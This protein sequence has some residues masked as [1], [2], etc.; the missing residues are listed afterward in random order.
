MC[1]LVG[2][3]FACL[4]TFLAQ[5]QIA[6]QGAEGYVSA[7]QLYSWCKLEDVSAKGLCT[8]YVLGVLDQHDALV[9]LGLHGKAYCLPLRIQPRACAL[10]A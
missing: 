1:R 10:E 6:A 8:G 9:A 7:S 2:F 5:E 3:S 4:V